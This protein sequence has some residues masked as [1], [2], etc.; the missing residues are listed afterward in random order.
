[1]SEVLSQSQIDSLLSSMEKENSR[2]PE[3]ASDERS[4]HKYR[5]YDFFSPK[6]YSKE[7]IKVLRNIYENYARILTS[8]INSLFRVVSNVEVIGIEEQRY[9]EY[10]NALY[11]SDVITLEK[12]NLPD[13]SKNPPAI[14][15][16]SPQLMTVMI[17]RMLGGD[18]MDTEVELGYTYTEIELALY[19]KIIKYFIAMAADVWASYLKLSCSFERIEENP[20]VFQGIGV[21]ETVMIVMLKIELQQTSGIMNIC[22][23]NT[24][25]QNIFGI[26]DQSMNLSALDEDRQ[27]N[28]DRQK[29]MGKLK[30]SHMEVS[31]QLAAVRLSL[32]DLYNLRAGDVINLGK[33]QNT[34]V[35]VMVEN[36]PWFT[37]TLGVHKK[38]TAVRLEERIRIPRQE[39]NEEEK[40]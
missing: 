18:G 29:I 10:S 5:K 26:I 37:G 28:E 38:N 21:D 3:N 20:S 33:P 4:Q 17:D 16:I 35:T 11:E 36:N 25:L 30:D 9:Y 27:K 40:Q 19:E 12:V 34:P 39:S 22:I 23:P 6:K 13:R 2:K 8:Q 14:L 24:L 32:E 15:Y 1:M 31:A 7:K